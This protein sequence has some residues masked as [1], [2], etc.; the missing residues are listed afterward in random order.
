[1]KSEAMLLPI[2][3]EFVRKWLPRTVATLHFATLHYSKE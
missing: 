2:E 1:M 3:A